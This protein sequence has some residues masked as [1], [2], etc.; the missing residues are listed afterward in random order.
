MARRGGRGLLRLNIPSFRSFNP[1]PVG[2]L[3][4]VGTLALLY[5]AFEL[6]NLPFIRGRREA[7]TGHDHSSRN[8]KCRGPELQRNDH[9]SV[10][11]IW[12]NAG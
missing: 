9:G 7:G 3:F 10:I 12:R 5:F 6:Q 8:G 4:I 1:L 2:A 11:S